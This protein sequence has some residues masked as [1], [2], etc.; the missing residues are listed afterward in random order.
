MIDDRTK[1]DIGEPFI[2]VRFS[3]GYIAHTPKGI[4]LSLDRGTRYTCTYKCLES[5]LS[6]SSL[7][8][9]E[10]EKTN[11][12]DVINDF[13][14]YANQVKAD[15]EKRLKRIDEHLNNQ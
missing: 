8:R 15:Y 9:D 12:Y 13:K 10:I 7:K 4:V 3:G 1:Y 5:Y 14:K 11:I 2:S 6:S